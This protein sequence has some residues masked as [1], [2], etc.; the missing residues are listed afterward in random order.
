[1]KTFFDIIFLFAVIIIWFMIAYQ[2]VLSL[3]GFSLYRR[4]LREKP[5][6]LSHLPPLP[7]ITIL[8]PAHNEELVIE[9]TLRNLLALD[10][11]SD[12]LEILVIDDASTDSTPELLDRMA[13][14]E[15]QLRV[16]HRVP[17]QGGRGK[18]AALNAAWKTCQNE[19]LA[20]Y[21]ADNRPEPDALK[22]LVAYLLAHPEL[23]A[24]HGMFRTGNRARNLL[25][26][27]INIEGLSFQWIV[28]AGRWRLLGISTLPGTNFVVRRSVLERLGGWDEEAL[29]E[30]SE[31]SIRMYQAGRKIAFVPYSVTWEQEPE[32]FQA[33]LPQR[34][35]WVRGNHYVIGKLL[36]SILRSRSRVLAVEM[37]YSLSLYYFFLAAIVGSDLVFILG[38]C[39]IKLI[40]IYGPFSAVWAM[41]L[42]LYQLEVALALAYAGECTLSN[43]LGATLMYFTYCQ[44]WLLVVFRALYADHVVHEKRVWAKTV[45]FDTAL[46]AA[47]R[48]RNRIPQMQDPAAP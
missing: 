21:D 37:L 5:Q 3:A 1:M 11:P 38:L 39:H 30:D 35:R 32:T 24:A 33:W 28:Q 44:A 27:F 23:G 19:F 12:R 26:R 29:T 13:A 25:T 43:L 14:R 7:G 47:G 45:R 8:V 41:A 48:L 40:S 18:S 31:L 2:F 10:Y 34:T 42:V 6:L 9:S 46:E 36:K 20:V 22:I 16:L 4:G 17:P 15:P